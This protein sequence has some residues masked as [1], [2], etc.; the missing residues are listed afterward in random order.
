ME[1]PRTAQARADR[2][3]PRAMKWIGQSI[4]IRRCAARRRII[5]V[6][7]IDRAVIIVGD[8]HR[9][10]RHVHDVDRPADVVVVLQE[11]GNERFLRFHSAVLVEIDDV[12][13]TA[14][15]VGLVPGAMPGDEDRVVIL[16]R[17]RASRIEAHAKRR[18]V[19]TKLRQWLGEFVAGVTPSE[20]RI[21]DVAAVAIGKAEIILSGVEKPIKLVLRRVLRKPIALVLG[22]I[23]NL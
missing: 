2:S 12:D 3:S 10:V 16:R 6:Q 8:Q 20:L 15:F 7:Q 22:E 1:K 11:A 5:F 14:K 17:E 9:A 21:L 13:V 4:E 18:H 19:R 23:Q